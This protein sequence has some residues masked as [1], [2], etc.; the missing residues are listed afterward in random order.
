M[1]NMIRR[2][3]VY[4]IFGSFFEFCSI[5]LSLNIAVLMTAYVS[6]CVSKS[7]CFIEFQV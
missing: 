3:W 1:S 5:S 2:N 6:I 7:S 4:N